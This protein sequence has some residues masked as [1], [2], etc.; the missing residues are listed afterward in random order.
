MSKT[1]DLPAANFVRVSALRRNRLLLSLI[2]L[3]MVYAIAVSIYVGRSY[4]DFS[5]SSLIVISVRLLGFMFANFVLWRLGVAMFVVRPKK[6]IQWMLQDLRSKMADVE[7]ATDA[8]ICFLSI[9]ALILTYTFLKNEIHAVNPT[10]WVEQFVQ[11]DRFL[12]GGVDPWT[13]LW[14][15]LGSPIVTTAVN[16]AYH[17]WFPMIYIAVCVAC[18]DRSDPNRSTVFLV[19]FALCWFVGGNVIATIFASVG[20]VYY[21]PFNLGSDFV[22]QMELLRKSHE[23]SPVWALN[24]HEMLLD[25]YRNNGL[26]GGISAMPSMHVASTVLLAFYGFTYSRW[27]GLALSVFAFIILLGSVHLA[28]HYAIDGYVSILLA[29]CFWWLSKRLTAKFGPST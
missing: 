2:A 3:Q 6:P 21:E 12:H 1:A 25:G 15:I 11:W 27:L 24:V 23:I 7:K 9:V 5:T 29:S 16:G 22:P 19:A 10:L 26:A 14:P 17:I 18:L 28:W 13:L 8:V 20:P 4:W